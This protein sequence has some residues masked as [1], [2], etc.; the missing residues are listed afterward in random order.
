MGKI[1][2]AFLLGVFVGAAGLVSLAC[3]IVGA[4]FEKECNETATKSATKTDE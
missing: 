2:I 4:K 1:I 3:I